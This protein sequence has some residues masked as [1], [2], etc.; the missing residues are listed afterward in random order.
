[1]LLLTFLIVFPANRTLS[2]NGSSKVHVCKHASLAMLFVQYQGGKY[3]ASNP[4]SSPY[5][6]VSALFS[7]SNAIIPSVSFGNPLRLHPLLEQTSPYPH[8]HR[9]VLILKSTISYQY[10]INI[11][12]NIPSSYPN[13]QLFRLPIFLFFGPYSGSNGLCA[14]PMA[15]VVP[16]HAE[17]LDEIE[18]ARMAI[19]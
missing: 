14:P 8:H 11:P 4:T 6:K 7:V 17:V 12:I 19:F 18:Q 13:R 16:A 9:T 10:H 5:N 1:M 3:S 2:S 15:I